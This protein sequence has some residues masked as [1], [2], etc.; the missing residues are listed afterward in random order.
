MAAIRE[1]AENYLETILI[2]SHEKSA[3]RSIDIAAELGFTKP[4]ISIAMRKLRED[5]YINVDQ[6]SGHITLSEKGLQIAEIMFE[7]HRII[8][9]FL[10]QIGVSEKT[11]L[12]DACKIE[13]IISDES[14][15]M[16]K[17]SMRRGLE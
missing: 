14:F 5:G 1:S 6:S 4:S 9:T 16:I 8:S 10:M 7:R 17:K 13:H 15:D 3:V 11:A 2:L 12:T